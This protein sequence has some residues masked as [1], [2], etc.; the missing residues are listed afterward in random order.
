MEIAGLVGKR[1]SDPEVETDCA[2]RMIK[3]LL[4]LQD[5]QQRSVSFFF[6]VLIAIYITST[7][8]T[9]GYGA[10]SA[11][12]L[13]PLSAVFIWLGKQSHAELGVVVG[14]KSLYALSVLMPIL[15]AS[16]IAGAALLT[17]HT[18]TTQTDWNNT[19]LNV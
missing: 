3:L 17:G 14:R 19:W 12:I 13:I 16:L 4:E 7:M 18:D 10:V 1:P 11:F 5:I 6:A 15:G 2:P 8:G 9:N